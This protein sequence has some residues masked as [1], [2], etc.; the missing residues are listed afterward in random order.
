VWDGLL[1]AGT[2][3]SLSVRTMSIQVT[4][5]YRGVKYNKTIVR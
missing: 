3:M 1:K 4:Y 2:R 5:T